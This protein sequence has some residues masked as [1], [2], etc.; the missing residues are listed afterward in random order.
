[1][2]S[3]RRGGGGASP[4]ALG[5]PFPEHT[6][7]SGEC[8]WH[9][10][11]LATFGYAEGSRPNSEGTDSCQSCQ[12]VWVGPRPKA[13]CTCVTEEG[14]VVFQ[15]R[16][17]GGGASTWQESSPEQTGPRAMLKGE[18]ASTRLLEWT[19]PSSLD[20]LQDYVCPLPPP[21]SG[22]PSACSSSGLYTFSDFL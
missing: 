17:D 7:A 20:S 19:H 14:A 3:G 18:P 10:E 5:G 8:A 15:P 13:G 22:G 1:M 12:E 6:G 2:C 21:S 16:A 4:H 9:V 11:G